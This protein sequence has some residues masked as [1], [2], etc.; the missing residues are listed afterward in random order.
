MA[1]VAVK[2]SFKYEGGELA[3]FSHALNWK[4]Y[5]YRKL[6][7]FIR[8]DVL[9]VGAGMGETTRMLSKAEHTSWLCLEPDAALAYSLG[10][11]I[12]SFSRPNNFSFQQGFLSGLP[13]EKRF[14]T[15]LYIDVL[16]HIEDDAGELQTA[17]MHLKRDGCLL[18]L[19]PAYQWLFTPFDKAI[20]HFRRYSKKT[21]S[22]AIPGIFRRKR[23]IYL[24]S[25]GFLASLANKCMLSQ[26]M[27]TVRQILVWDR[28][29]V[30]FSSFA[31][32]L[33]G[34]TFGKSLLGV[35]EKR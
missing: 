22:A 32:P 8:G 30:R 35:W 6:A 9:E 10:K 15:I 4:K 5:I 27:P 18:I 16:E 19:V 20:G 1:E 11:T 2:D 21:L 26:S 13:G 23:L 14:D 29:M 24:D 7:P 12:A 28:M 25:V 17:A 3:L 34:Y 31:D 33:M